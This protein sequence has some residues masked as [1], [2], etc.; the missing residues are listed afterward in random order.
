MRGGQSEFNCL[1]RVIRVLAPAFRQ[2]AWES[3]NILIGSRVSAALTQLQLTQDIAHY[4]RHSRLKTVK[5]LEM[6]SQ[7]TFHRKE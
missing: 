5:A 1:D 7:C 2:A 3:E 4:A 6:L